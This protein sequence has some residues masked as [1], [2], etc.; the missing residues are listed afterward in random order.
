M[1]SARF[2]TFILTLLGVSIATPHYAHT[3]ELLLPEDTIVQDEVRILSWNVKFLPRI[4]PQKHNQNPL[5][6]ARIIPAHIINDS[7]DIVVLQE[8]FDPVARRIIHQQLKDIYPYKA[9]PANNRHPFKLNSGV[10]MYSKYPL[11]EVGSIRY[12]E[13]EKE[14]C[15]AQKGVLLVE[16]D[17]NGKTIQVLGTHMEAGGTASHK[18]GQYHEMAA[19]AQQH[20]KP[21]VPQFFC[22]DFNTAQTDTFLYPILINTLKAEN[23]PLYSALQYTADKLENDMNY[24]A[25]RQQPR[26]KRKVIDFIF[27]KPNGYEPRAM[28]RYVRQY[29]ER[30]S[31]HYQDL[32]DHNAV[33]MRLLL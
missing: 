22:G 28:K 33:L 9:G 31:T 10:L 25:K 8:A 5:K 7:I 23:G 17:I 26:N 2:I 6:R 13:C 30:W 14:D 27:Y 21:G 16:A 20:E 3:N 29:K 19:L 18:I 4:I 24:D 15:L 1:I 12:K 11:K 32:S